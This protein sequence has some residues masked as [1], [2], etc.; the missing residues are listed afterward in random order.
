M[1]GCVAERFSVVRSRDWPIWSQSNTCS[2][3][4]TYVY[5]SERFFL[6]S[7]IVLVAYMYPHA[8][9]YVICSS[10]VASISFCDCK[11]AAMATLVGMKGR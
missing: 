8:T 3:T 1:T 2:L 4:M 11:T 6:S 5:P 7:S 9:L 10:Q